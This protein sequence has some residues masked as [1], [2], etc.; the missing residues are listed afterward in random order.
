LARHFMEKEIGEQEMTGY[1][2]DIWITTTALVDGFRLCEAFLGPKAQSAKPYGQDLTGTIQQLVG[3][4]FRTLEMHQDFW[5]PRTGSEP[6]P[7]FGF[8]YDLALEPLKLNKRRLMDNVRSNIEQLRPILEAI[9][10]PATLTEMG[11]MT[12]LQDREFRYPDELWVH[13][14]Y[15]F[16]G[17][18]HRSVINRDHILQA[19]APLYRARVSSIVLE[20]EK[21]GGPKMEDRFESLG[22]QF[23]RSKPYLI[24]RW[25]ADTGG[26][27]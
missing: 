1:G 2:L 16:A 3:A 19:L 13:T 5:L 21:A 9:L 23:E 27:R 15:E 26:D 4:L 17:S 24:E 11:R 20:N 14:I 8:Q 7:R 18:Y 22:Q 6:P 10:T 12:A 25:N